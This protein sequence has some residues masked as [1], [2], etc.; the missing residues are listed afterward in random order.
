MAATFSVTHDAYRLILKHPIDSMEPVVQLHCGR[1]DTVSFQVIVQSDH[2][3]SLRT[4]P[5]EWMTTRNW[6]AGPHEKVRVAVSAPFPAQCFLEGFSTDDDGLQKADM[7]LHQD[8]V[9]SNAHTPTAVWCE[10]NVPADAQPG[11]YQVDVS[12]YAA[13]LNDDESCQGTLSLPLTVFDYVLPQAKDYHFNLNLWQHVSNIARNHD[14]PL[15]SDA[16]FRVLEN[17]ARSLAAI[18]QRNITV[19]ASEIP[20]RGQSCFI[21]REYNGDLF[22]YCMA[23]I[24]RKK[25]GTFDFDFSPMQRYIELCLQAGMGPSIDLIGLTR[26]WDHPYMTK[27]P[28]CKDYPEAMRLRYLDEKDGCMKYVREGWIMREYVQALEKHFVE[29]GLIDH[30]MLEADEPDDLD[31]YAAT[32]ALL[33]ELCPR[34]QYQVSINHM[35]FLDQFK[36]KLSAMSPYIDFCLERYDE[37]KAFLAENPDKKL[38]WYICCGGGFP[39]SYL[40]TPPIENRVIGAFTYNLGFDGF[41]R[42]AY[43]CWPGNPREQSRYSAFEAGDSYF[44]YPGKDGQVLLSL[45]YKN[46]QQGVRDYELLT[47]TAAK[48][49]PEAAQSILHMLAS[50]TDENKPQTANFSTK[51]QDYEAARVRMLQMLSQSETH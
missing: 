41:A 32:M 22:E 36:H 13:G 29:H 16:H 40:R 15:W 2:H 44:V 10:I 4:T 47:L 49:G 11:T 33:E 12:V 38:Y 31:K 26:V 34:F 5:G 30:V 42:W 6:Q 9:E 1:R 28:L 27:E 14:V 35:E 18:G 25:D 3:Y 39:N 37:L 17:Y 43:T 19:I 20:W 23:R 21:E 48:Y 24:T 45:R 46:L 8:A 51:W 7:L 50:Y